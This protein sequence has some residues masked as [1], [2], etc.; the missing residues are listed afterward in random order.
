MT[1]T[2]PQNYAATSAPLPSPTVGT[3]Q[4]PPSSYFGQQ[5]RAWSAQQIPTSYPSQQPQQRLPWQQQE[6]SAPPPRPLQAGIGCTGQRAFSVGSGCSGQAATAGYGQTGVGVGGYAQPG[7]GAYG[8][9]AVGGC[10]TGCR[11]EYRQPAA[12]A[13]DFCIIAEAAKKAQVDC[14]VRDMGEVGL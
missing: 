6:S 4:P 9:T 7:L 8:Q 11:R 13:Q 3:K 1:T 12:T 10:G 2:P 5:Q 14:M